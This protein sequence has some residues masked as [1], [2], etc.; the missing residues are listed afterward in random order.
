MQPSELTTAFSFAVVKVVKVVIYDSKI[1][2]LFNFRL[3]LLNFLN[4]C[5]LIPRVSSVI[6]FKIITL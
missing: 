3:I 1:S 5:N 6:V 4:L 2:P